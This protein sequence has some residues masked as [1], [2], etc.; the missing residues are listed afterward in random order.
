MRLDKPYYVGALTKLDVQ[1]SLVQDF[2]EENQDPINVYYDNLIQQQGNI[3]AVCRWLDGRTT[4][5]VYT[6][7]KKWATDLEIRFEPNKT[8]IRRFSRL[9]PSCMKKQIISIGAAKYNT[10][11]IQGRIPNA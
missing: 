8:F 9:L 5:E 6:D 11:T 3:P 7:Y 1:R 2:V 4:E 10:F